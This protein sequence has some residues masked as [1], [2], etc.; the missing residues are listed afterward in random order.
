MGATTELKNFQPLQHFRSPFDRSIVAIETQHDEATG[1]HFL[2]WRHIQRTF[3]NVGT[4]RAGNVAIQFMVDD[5]LE[6][7]A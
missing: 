5:T 1:T 7:Y 6:E 4:V 2:L 3:E